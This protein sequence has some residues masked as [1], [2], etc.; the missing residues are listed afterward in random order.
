L[1]AQNF[2]ISMIA[3]G[4]DTFPMQRSDTLRVRQLLDL[5]IE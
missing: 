3:E 5:H 2:M 1:S 4:Y